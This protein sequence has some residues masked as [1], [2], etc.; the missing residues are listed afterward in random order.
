MMAAG[1]AFLRPIEE[2]SVRLSFVDFDGKKS[3]AESRTLGLENE[4][5]ENFVKIHC[6]GV[7]EGIKSLCSWIVK[8][9]K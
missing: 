2:F 4:L 8:Q 3:L 5:P 9:S 6:S 7:Y 1:P